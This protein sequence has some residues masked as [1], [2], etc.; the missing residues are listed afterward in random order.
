M[1]TTIACERTPPPSRVALIMR[2]ESPGMSE[3][4]STPIVGRVAKDQ[5]EQE[6]RGSSTA[7]FDPAKGPLT[8][9]NKGVIVVVDTRPL[10]HQSASASRTQTIPSGGHFARS[11]PPLDTTRLLTVITRDA[12]LTA[13]E[14]FRVVECIQRRV[15]KTKTPITSFRARQCVRGDKMWPIVE[16][17]EGPNVEVTAVVMMEGGNF[18]LSCL[19][20][21]GT[22]L[23]CQGSAK[24]YEKTELEWVAGNTD[25]LKEL[26]PVAQCWLGAA[27]WPRSDK[28]K[29]PGESSL[30][31]ATKQEYSPTFPLL[32][33]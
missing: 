28:S 24:R 3:D 22:G 12:S 9:R 27:H 5:V 23:D 7:E 17:K 1:G 11:V 19:T 2:N 13:D 14:G 30:D 10:D 8:D 20:V 26:F 29:T 16:W 33:G 18:P 32:M 6:Q 25:D 4:K 15:V 31:Y 21:C